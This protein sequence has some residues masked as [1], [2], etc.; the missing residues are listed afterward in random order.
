MRKHS[1]K[2]GESSGSGLRECMQVEAG[3]RTLVEAWEREKVSI[4]LG[5]EGCREK[6]YMVMLVGKRAW[7]RTQ[8][9][10]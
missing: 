6:H 5:P 8:H 7:Q 4:G 2:Q 1:T 9:S 3:G 10:A